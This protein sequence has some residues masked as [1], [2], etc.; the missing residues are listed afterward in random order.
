[1]AAWPADSGDTADE[2]VMVNKTEYFR[3]RMSKYE[4]ESVLR[5]DEDNFHRIERYCDSLSS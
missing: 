2:Q 3:L 5:K 4:L 1:M